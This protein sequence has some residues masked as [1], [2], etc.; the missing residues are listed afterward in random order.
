VVAVTPKRGHAVNELAKKLRISETPVMARI[1]DDLLLLD[2][3]TVMPDED[4]AL[5]RVLEQALA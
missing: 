5:S 3:R 4:E 1:E 2:P